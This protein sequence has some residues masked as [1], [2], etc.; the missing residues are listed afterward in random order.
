MKKLRG[1]KKEKVTEKQQILELAIRDDDINNKA[2]LTC[3]T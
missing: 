3:W 1:K 2:A